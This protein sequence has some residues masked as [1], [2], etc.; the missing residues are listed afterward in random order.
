[1][2]GKKVNTFNKIQ[3][4]ILNSGLIPFEYEAQNAL[5]LVPQ[6]PIDFNKFNAHIQLM[7]K[8]EVLP[9]IEFHFASKNETTTKH[10]TNHALKEANDIKN[11]FPKKCL[12]FNKMTTI[13]WSYHTFPMNPI[14]IT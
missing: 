2:S 12:P 4:S 1:M 13:V 8:Y 11:T 6:K 10:S 14:L 9:K 7:R 3:L 5:K